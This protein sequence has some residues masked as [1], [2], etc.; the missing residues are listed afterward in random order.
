MRK[1]GNERAGYADVLYTIPGCDVNIG[2]YEIR[3]D[4]ISAKA[5]AVAEDNRGVGH[6]GVIVYFDK[7]HPLSQEDKQKALELTGVHL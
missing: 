7:A 4:P 6:E 5:L 1:V 3:V 2:H